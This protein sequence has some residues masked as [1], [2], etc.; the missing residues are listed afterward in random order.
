MD[1]DSTI[2]ERHSVRRF[3]STKKPNW[4]DILEAIEAARK[5]PLAGNIPSLKFIIVNEPERIAKLAEA[6]QQDF[7]ADCAY[8][9]VVCSK[10]DQCERSYGERA[11]RY[12]KQQAGAAIENFLLKITDLGLATCWVG[13]F[14]DHMI[15]HALQIPEEVE[16]EAI[17]PIGYEKKPVGQQR[18]KL[19]LQSCLYFNVWKNKYMAGIRKPEGM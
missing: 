13:A 12:C 8:I 6:S 17:F 2:K 4:Q 1:L 3:M 15:K 9:V 10:G 5:A 19:D 7:I 11:K 18:K 16:V 14:A